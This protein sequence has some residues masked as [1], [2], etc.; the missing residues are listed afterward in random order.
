[1]AIFD[2][3]LRRIVARVVFDGPALAGKTTNMTSLCAMMPLEK[4]PEIYT[5]GSLRGRTMFFD[6]MEMPAGKL[7]PFEFRCQVLS[8]PGQTKR[9]YRRKPLVMSADVIVFVAD[10][11]PTMLDENI[12]SLGLLRRYLRE[13]RPDA[14]PIVLQANKQDA[15]NAFSP[16]QLA[17]E[18]HMDVSVEVHAAIAKSGLG[19]RESFKGAVKLAMQR[20]QKLAAQ[21]GTQALTGASESPD[22]LFDRML[23]LEDEQDEYETGESA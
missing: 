11:T 14:I 21:R 23:E 16:K 17:D 15:V 9:S 13:R 12:Q 22:E 7:G 6:W 20:V 3:T 8:V 4:R 19:V 2:P 18:L 5:P 1:V 10:S